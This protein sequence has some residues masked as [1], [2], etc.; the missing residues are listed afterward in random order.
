MT[1]MQTKGPDLAEASSVL[2]ETGG[3]G[4]QMAG[5]ICRWRIQM[6]ASQR[7]GPRVQRT[8][9][10]GRCGTHVNAELVPRE[11]RFCMSGFRAALIKGMPR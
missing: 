9:C 5:A 7:Q 8:S 3:E 11:G 2:R 1:S 4:G 10:L 6:M